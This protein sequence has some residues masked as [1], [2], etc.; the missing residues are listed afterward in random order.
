MKRV[1]YKF[2]EV[3]SIENIEK[4]GKKAAK[5][6]SDHKD[7]IWYKK[8]RDRL[9]L[10][11]QKMLTEKIY[12]VTPED[13]RVFIKHTSSGKDR[14]IH[15]L[16]FWPFRVAQHAELM[17]MGPR[18]V[19][20]LNDDVYNC[21]PGRGITSKVLRH[22]MVHKLKRALLDPYSVYVLKCDIKKFYPSVNNKIY[23]RA[24]R[25]ELKD[26]DLIWLL[27]QHNFSSKGLP[28][29]SPDAQMGSHLVL[30]ILDRFIKEELR[31]RYYFRYADDIVILSDSKAELHQWMWRI[32]NFMY[33]EL[34]LEMKGD[35][36]IFP[37]KEG[38]DVGGYVF[39][40]GHTKLRKRIKKT[41]V[42]RHNEKSM[43]SY[44]GI[45][46]HCDARNLERE[47]IKEDNKHMRISDF[48]IKIERP[49][50]GDP[51]KMDKLVDEEIDILDF[52]VRESIKKKGHLW[53]MMQVS[54][55]GKIRI[56]KGGYDH[57]AA[58]LKK[59]KEMFTEEGEPIT[60]EIKKQYLP[61]EG[62]VI[63]N[64]RGYYI[65]GTLKSN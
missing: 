31:A 43:A 9:N 27:D 21:L 52:D 37:V 4:A 62:V 23:R 26:K 55:Q 46:K 2:K 25:K 14:E 60:L 10:E 28:I 11:L 56:V 48:N 12:R 16:P 57:I 7:V 53:V 5:D 35:R 50:D 39:Y 13:Y 8:N 24:Y 64:N 34:K 3:C 22:N 63:R 29:G 61:L 30:R 49:F 40:P 20:S 19:K 42:K 17:V 47:V 1:G 32:R 51:I 38:I 6:K 44:K 33:Y 41:M 36:R 65:E 58:Y 54:Y 59:L 45:L 18:W 15:K